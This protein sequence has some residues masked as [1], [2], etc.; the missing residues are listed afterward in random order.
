M[1]SGQTAAP[2]LQ[3]A[4][5]KSGCELIWDPV[6]IQADVV[7]LHNPAFLKF[8]ERMNLQIIAHRLIVVTHEN[9]TR[10]GGALAFDVAGCLDQ[11]DRAC[12]AVEKFVAPIS[13]YNRDTVVNWLGQNPQGSRWQVLPENWFNICDFDFQTP[14]PTP[15]DRRGRLSRPGFEK[16]PSLD[17]LEQCFPE[18]AETNTILGAD[19]LMHLA[20][21]H[22]HW[23]L[24][25]FGGMDVKTFFEDIDFMLYF[26]SPSWRES[27][28]RVLAEATAAGKIVITDT[29]TAATFGRGLI[30]ASPDQVGDII[31]DL[32]LDPKA[33]EKHVEQAQKSLQSFGSSKFFNF[34]SVQVQPKQGIA[35]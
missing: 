22:P 3:V 31:K 34:F 24:I 33:Y 7:I 18:T 26:T 32:I 1:F 21:D 23:T 30:G 19:S 12:M 15:K 5:E 13:A 25:P 4:L 20:G 2:V 14:N 6:K 29:E 8:D 10:P 28:G 27:F 11:I 9:F 35:A 17:A 16:F